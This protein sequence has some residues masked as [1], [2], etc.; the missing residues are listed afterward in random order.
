M[1]KAEPQ[2]RKRLNQ[3]QLSLLHIIYRFRFVTTDLVAR[4][5][6]KSNST[7]VYPR[8]ATLMEQGYIGQNYS[9]EY[10][11]RGQY[12]TYYLLP[13]GI[14]ALKKRTDVAYS[15]KVLHNIL[16]DRD[17]SEQFINH[18]LEVFE[19][20]CQM[21]TH[22]GDRLQFFTKS[23]LAAH[24]HDHFPS[25]LPDA[26]IR[27]ES[28]GEVRQY[29]LD[30]HHETR[31]FFVAT[32]RLK[33][34]AAHADSKEWEATDSELPK[35]LALCD[36]QTMQKRL[37]KRIAKEDHSNLNF[38]TT[39]KD[40]LKKLADNANVWQPVSEPEALQSLEAA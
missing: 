14:R 35:V 26:Y 22:Y 4:Y 21:K 13:P 27:L 10:R 28:D 3:K 31:P 1:V 34:Y 18:N 32:R 9:P 29:F 20:Y 38:L 16:A 30:L 19:A 11:L 40:A 7:T 33:Q 36:T 24:E 5:Q 37:Q 12:A 15:S 17:A 25:P 23:D 39:T 6:G 2:H 8:L